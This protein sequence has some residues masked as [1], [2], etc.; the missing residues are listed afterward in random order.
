[1][2]FGT[3]TKEEID[4]ALSKINHH[5]AVH[6]ELTAITERISRKLY[7]NYIN[8]NEQKKNSFRIFQRKVL[9]EKK[10]FD[11]SCAYDFDGVRVHRD[12][13]YLKKYEVQLQ[14][15]ELKVHQ[16]YIHGAFKREL[17]K[18][19]KK[20]KERLTFCVGGDISSDEIYLLCDMEELTKSHEATIKH[21]YANENGLTVTDVMNAYTGD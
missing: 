21:Y 13:E 4:K 15:H 9:T 18:E 16:E 10:F 3:W 6:N 11:Y 20:F 8:I 2:N 7:Q 12:N 1:M 5:Y 17:N 14:E 19:I